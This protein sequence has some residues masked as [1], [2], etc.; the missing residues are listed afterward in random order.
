MTAIHTDTEQAA[1]EGHS[2]GVASWQDVGSMLGDGPRRFH[3]AEAL[4]EAIGLNWTV[5]TEPLV[6][7]RT[8]DRI[9]SM[10]EVI[11]EDTGRTIGVVK[12]RYTPI[13][14]VKAFGFLPEV[15]GEHGLEV[16][17]GGI[18]D[19]G[20]RTWVLCKAGEQV[21][22]DRILPNGEADRI[23]QHLLFWG[24]HD[25]STSHRMAAI[26][27]AFWCANAL[28]SAWRHAENRWSITHTKSAPERLADA[29]AKAQEAL[30][31]MDS[32]GEQ[33][34][35]LE[36]ERFN[37]KEMRAYAEDLLNEVQGLI[38]PKTAEQLGEKANG[39]PR[40]DTALEARRRRVDKMV[41]LFEG[42][43]ASCRG[44]TKLDAYQAVTEFIDHHRRRAK[45]GG[46]L[47]RQRMA[48]FED[49]IFS[50]TTQGFREAALRRLR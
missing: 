19:E 50:H 5:R 42:E 44:A 23:E 47:A 43:G 17:N 13:Q 40:T 33:M 46:D 34:I 22:P 16:V 8:G 37:A 39:E 10:R 36:A 27:H 48:R 38:T 24:S 31:W 3:T 25:G 26:P 20:A 35:A 18:L 30:G 9:G 21:F 6:S 4:C 12:K 41:T 7:A 32:F 14:N 1:H 15:C 49:T 11:R 28:A 2:V 29:L 45:M